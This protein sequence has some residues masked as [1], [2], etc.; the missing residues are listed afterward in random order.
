MKPGPYARRIL[1]AYIESQEERDAA[2]SGKLSRIE[3]FM[4]KLARLML[5]LERKVDTFLE[6]AEL[7]DPT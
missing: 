7:T 4:P 1:I 2:L 5:R 6:N 3:S